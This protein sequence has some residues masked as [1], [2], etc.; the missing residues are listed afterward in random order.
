LFHGGFGENVLQTFLRK[1]GLPPLEKFLLPEN[2]RLRRQIGN[3]LGDL[4]CPA[5]VA[6]L[7]GSDRVVHDSRFDGSQATP[8]IKIRPN[9]T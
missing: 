1:A 9:P 7:L 8:Y 5:P 4:A 6:S 2:P 3:Y